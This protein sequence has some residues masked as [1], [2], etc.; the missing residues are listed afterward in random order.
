M[1]RERLSGDLKTAVKS[2]DA[3]RAA[4]LRLICATIRDRDSASQSGD[5]ATGVSD[6]AIM[7]LLSRMIS[8]REQ[9]IADY[10]ESGRLDLAEQER[11]EIAVIKGY[12]PRQMSETEVQTAISE[13]LRRTGASSVRDINRV[14]AHLKSKHTGQMDFSRACTALKNTFR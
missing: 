11:A 13:A 12:L 6:G 7:D 3:N 14:M 8:Q 4:T 10:E 2:D 9:S 1:I 5:N